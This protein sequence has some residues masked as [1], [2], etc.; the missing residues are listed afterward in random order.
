MHKE[1]IRQLM[2]RRKQQFSAEDLR[3]WSES[4]AERLLD[5]PDIGGVQTIVA[6]HS[7]PYEVCTHRL[8]QLLLQRGKQVFLPTVGENHQLTLHR[9]E[10]EQALREGAFHIREAQGEELRDYDSVETVI[11][12][13]VAFDNEG[14]RLGRGGG[15]YDRLLPRLRKARKIGLSFDFQV[16]DQ[17][18]TDSHDIGM[19]LLISISTDGKNRFCK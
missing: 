5:Y 7:L 2:A 16:I 8:L 19:D 4:V 6:Y 17:L 15:Y 9:Y 18:P 13:G 11:V 14:H 1:E 12:P 10:G 3:R